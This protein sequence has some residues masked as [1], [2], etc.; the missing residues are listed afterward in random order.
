MKEPGFRDGHVPL[1]IVEKKVQPQYLEVAIYEEVIH[2]GTKVMLEE[3]KEIKF[4]GN[5]YDLKHHTMKLKK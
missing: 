1:D 2:A 4:I 3:N 5:V